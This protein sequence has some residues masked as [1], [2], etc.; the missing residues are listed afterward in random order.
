M[1]ASVPDSLADGTYVVAWQ[2][3]SA[4][5]HRVRG[6]FTFSVG[7]PS[8]VTP[9]V[10]DGLFDGAA[11]SSSDDILLGVG[12][13]VSYA[14]V[15]LLVGGLVL[16]GA[17]T[18][19]G[20]GTR[21]VGVLL[22]GA[23]ESAFV[24]T[25]WMVAAQANL[26]GGSFLSWGAVADTQSGQWWIARLV[27]IALFSVLIALRSRLVVRGGIVV[28]SALAL[29][30]LAVVAGCARWLE[31]RGVPQPAFAGL[32]LRLAG[33]SPASEARWAGYVWPLCLIGISLL[34]IFYRES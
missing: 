31:L 19:S 27:V 33:G 34:L 1:R 16:A 25:L 13:F 5:S 24:G 9:G 20:I 30:V 22:V 3:V 10:L 28:V 2:G 6:S 29:G 8:S 23:A 17:L 21:R 14:G 32:P 4:D 26:I 18:P 12:R 15:G 11:D 7:V